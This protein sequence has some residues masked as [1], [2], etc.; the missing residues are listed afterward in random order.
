MLLYYKLGDAERYEKAGLK[1]RVSCPAMHAA[2]F[3]N[4]ANNNL[5]AA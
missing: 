1:S 4:T 2:E 5:F 3:G